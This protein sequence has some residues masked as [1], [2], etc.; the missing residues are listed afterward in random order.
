[1]RPA[2]LRTTLLAV[3]AVCPF[4]AA[5]QD[6]LGAA[7]TRALISSNTARM[8]NLE[9]GLYLRMYFEPAGQFVVQRDDGVQFDGLWSVRPDGTLCTIASNEICGKLQKQVDGTYKRDTG[10]GGFAHHWV[11]ITPG[12]DF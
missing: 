8:Q 10:A 3:I 9:N 2:A 5:A 11:K 6:T 1:M 4:A 7:E 12:R